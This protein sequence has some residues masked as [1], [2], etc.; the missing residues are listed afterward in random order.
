MGLLAD[1]VGSAAV[2]AGGAMFMFVFSYPLFWLLDLH[3]VLWAT[4]GI[5]FGYGVGFGAMAGAQGAFLANLFP[6]QYRFSGLAMSRELNG[7]L[8]AGPTPLIAA[9]LVTAAGGK[10]SLVVA[11]LMVCCALSILAILAVRNR[12]IHH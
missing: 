3:S 8:I 11:Y 9:Y 5:A 4:V 10:P 1:R 7:V 6:T 2:Y 12:S